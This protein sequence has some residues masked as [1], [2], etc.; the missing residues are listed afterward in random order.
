MKRIGLALAEALGNGLI[1]GIEGAINLV[2]KGL[3]K[4]VDGLNKIGGWLGIKDKIGRIKEV[5]LPRINLVKE[6]ENTSETS[7]RSGS[8]GGSGSTGGT[9][10]AGSRL[11][12]TSVSAFAGGGMLDDLS[13]LAHGTAYAIAGED[14]AEIV[15]KGRNG[16]GVA[17]VEQIADAQY[18]ALKDYRL[19]ETITASASAIVNGIV[20][21]MSMN[22]GSNKT[23]IVVQI[24]EKDFKSYIIKTVN[25]TLNAKGRKNLNAVTAY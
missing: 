5:S 13:K 9:G 10:G 16:T 12:M 24:G 23:E 7:T 11:A 8:A 20:S 18:M 4:F 15:A 17:N 6:E 25:E 3:N 19:N 21:G 14:G 1:S 22:K 2:V